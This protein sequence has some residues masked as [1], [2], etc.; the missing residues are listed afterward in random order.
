METG[1]EYLRRYNDC[2]LVCTF[3][4]DGQ[5]DIED[6]EKFIQ[7]MKHHKKTQ[8]VFGSRFVEKTNTN[9]PLVRRIVLRL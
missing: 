4:A 5:H 6:L 7:I 8:V 2:E 3:D 9:I 1:F